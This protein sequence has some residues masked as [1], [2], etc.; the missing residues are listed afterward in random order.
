MPLHD[1][2]SNAKGNLEKLNRIVSTT[3]GLDATL[4]AIQYPALLL[5]AA[6]PRI[7]K[8]DSVV[9]MHF[10]RLANRLKELGLGAKALYGLINSWRMFSRLPALVGM[11][12]STLKLL[13]AFRARRAKKTEDDDTPGADKIKRSQGGVKLGI[14]ASKLGFGLAFQLAENIAL[15]SGHGVIR[16]ISEGT[17]AHLWVLSARFWMLYCG[18][19][20]LRL[21]TELWV[22]TV[23]ER[24]ARAVR[25]LGEQADA[26]NTV[27]AGGVGVER[28][29]S[30][31]DE[32]SVVLVNA[33]GEP[34]AQSADKITAIVSEKM[35][36]LEENTVA[37]RSKEPHSSAMSAQWW[38]ELYVNSAN[39]PL[40]LHYSTMS[41]ASGRGPLNDT[42]IALLGA[43][44]G[45]IG[46]S[47]TWRQET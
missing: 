14:A 39:A 19:E 38:Q 29:A 44:T 25:E 2:L 28:R 1:S 4:L 3:A 24:S 9:P 11:C 35:N 7:L 10:P 43:V 13:A 23:A 42:L 20:F 36:N 41:A 27:A 34:S 37:I 46:F 18:A 33:A 30:S 5:A 31:G 12:L 22:K 47:Q 26:A 6:L 17:R 15:L 32:G 21:A 40:S 45:I 8:H 16:N